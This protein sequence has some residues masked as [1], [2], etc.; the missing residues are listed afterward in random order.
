MRMLVE[1]DFCCYL[2]RE[3]LD[4]E[5]KRKVHV[6]HDHSCCPGAFSCGDCVR[7]IAC[8]GCNKAI[9]R[10]GDSPERMRRAADRL[11]AANER[12]AERRRSRP[13]QE[14][15]PLNVVPIEREAKGA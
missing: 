9:A 6:E 13:V 2:C 12:V 1:Q 14:A 7:G 15:L 11:E 3:P 5:K 8:A 4:L 10:F